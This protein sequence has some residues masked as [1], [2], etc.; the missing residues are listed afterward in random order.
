MSHYETKM[1]E[2]VDSIAL[3][4]SR[5]ANKLC[6]GHVPD[7]SAM[8]PG[9]VCVTA[10]TEMLDSLRYAKAV[11]AI[12][13]MPDD[14]PAPAPKGKPATKDDV[15]KALNTFSRVHGVAA[16]KSVLTQFG[17][18]LGD[19]PEEKYGELVALLAVTQ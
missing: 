17:A 3:S 7:H 5:I 2:A 9:T 18:T 8:A 19:V 14:I 11:Q 6:L 12:V 16:A 15:V 4:L 1:L 10:T 13:D